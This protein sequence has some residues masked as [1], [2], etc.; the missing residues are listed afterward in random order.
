MAMERMTSMV[1]FVPML[2]EEPV[3]TTAEAEAHSQFRRPSIAVTTK[4]VS[5]RARSFK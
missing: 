2:E 4:R 1:V 5:G 3:V